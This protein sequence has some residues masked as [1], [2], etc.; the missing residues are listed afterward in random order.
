MLHWALVFLIIALIAGV[1]GF[2]RVYVAAAG[3]A[4]ILFFIFLVLLVIS[5]LFG[6]QVRLSLSADR[7][8]RPRN[9]RARTFNRGVKHMTTETIKILVVGDDEEGCTYVAN[10]LSAKHWQ[11]D[12]AW[13]G[14]KALELARKTPTMPSCSTTE[15]RDMTAPRSAAAFA[16]LSPQPAMCS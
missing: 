9:L 8:A 7:K 16:A 1:F 5:L 14:S 6:L 11:T 10:M 13:I 12:I 3:I 2:T 4:R 15:G